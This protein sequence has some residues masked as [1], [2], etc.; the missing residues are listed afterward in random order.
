MFYPPQKPWTEFSSEEEKLEAFRRWGLVS[1]K[2]KSMKP[3]VYAGPGVDRPMRCNVVG[4][5]EP[6]FAVV[7]VEGNLS[8]IHGDFLAETQPD[9]PGKLLDG[10]TVPAFL[11]DYVVIDL[12]TTGFDR[13]IDAIIEVAAIRYSYGQEVS[14]FQQLVNPHRTLSPEIIGLTGITQDMVDDAP[15]FDDIGDALLEFLGDSPIVG[16][17][18]IGFDIPFLEYHLRTELHNPKA[19]TLPIARRT[20]PDLPSYKLQNLD[21]TL[22]LGATTAHRAMADVETTHALLMACMVPDKYRRKTALVATGNGAHLDGKTDKIWKTEKTGKPGKTGKIGIGTNSNGNRK[23]AVT[24]NEIPNRYVVLDIETTGRSRTND[25]IIEIAANKYE[26]GV[27]TDS[28]HR[29][30]NPF[31]MLP[32]E[33]VALTGLTQEDVESGCAIEDVKGEFLDFISDNLLVG[34]NIITF[35]VPFLSVQLGVQIKNTLMDTLHLSREAFP[36]INNYKLEHLNDVLNLRTTRS[37]RAMEDVETTNALLIACMEPEKYNLQEQTA[38]ESQDQSEGKSF[39]RKSTKNHSPK[40]GKFA[41]Y[42]ADPKSI[43]PTVCVN[44]DSPLC[45]KIIVFTGELSI[46]RESAM[47]WAVNAGAVLK[48]SVSGKTNYLVVGKQ[49]RTIVGADGI[50]GKEEKAYAL[51]DSG[52]GHIE[53]ISEEEFLKLAGGCGNG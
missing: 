34:H 52:K 51:N 26:N 23:R 16:H 18:A 11:Q 17:N 1:P 19:D 2:A 21:K 9:I 6:F 12:E 33:I 25:R 31:R 30:I 53:I 39:G 13:H 27:L 40:M 5:Q 10:L 3:V 32:M 41:K 15:C 8:C 50:S 47:Q 36:Q 4:C 49:D 7:E 29:I 24:Q 14:R 43:Q 28:F 35:D 45:G 46:S 37:H 22:E 38:L 48:N 44:Q 20:F 42:S